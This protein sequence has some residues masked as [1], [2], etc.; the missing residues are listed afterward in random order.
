MPESPGLDRLPD[1]RRAAGSARAGLASW[2]RFGLG[3]AGVVVASLSFVLHVPGAVR[4]LDST[5]S[6]DAYITDPLGRELTSGDILGIPSELQREALQLIP[7]DSDYVLMLPPDP[8]S[9][10]K[11]G[12]ATITWMTVGPFLHY[13]LLPARPVDSTVAHYVICWHCDTTPWDGITTWLWKTD[14]GEAIGRV[15]R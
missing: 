2:I 12:M 6:A 11:S 8:E 13:L 3:V 5:V 9:A 4:R 1:T 15:T 14:E 10:A 7:K